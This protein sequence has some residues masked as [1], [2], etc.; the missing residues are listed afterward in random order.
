MHA[1][2]IDSRRSFP[3]LSQSGDPSQLPILAHDQ[4]ASSEQPLSSYVSSYAHANAVCC[5]YRTRP[6]R[7]TPDVP[8]SSQIPHSESA[9]SDPVELRG[10]SRALGKYLL[11]WPLGCRD[12]LRT[13]LPCAGPCAGTISERSWSLGNLT[14]PS[15]ARDTFSDRISLAS[16]A[17]SSR[18]QL[19]KAIL[20]LSC[21]TCGKP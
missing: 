18:A 1:C 9:E 10:S 4:Q 3:S 16:L 7:L 17:T 12:G 21:D 15:L 11:R 5:C 20:K 2:R 19:S 14:P 8:L 6:H 13:K